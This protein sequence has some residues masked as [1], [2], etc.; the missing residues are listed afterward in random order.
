MAR[1][2]MVRGRQ[3]HPSSE[4]KLAKKK[5]MMI[6]RNKE[7]KTATMVVRMEGRRR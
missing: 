2:A 7:M 4:D 3:S 5:V 6:T 1:K